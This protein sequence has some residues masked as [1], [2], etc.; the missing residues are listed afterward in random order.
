MKAVIRAP[1]RRQ[2]TKSFKTRFEAVDRTPCHDDREKSE[3]CDFRFS[4][5]RPRA[6]RGGPSLGPRLSAAMR[7]FVRVT[8][9][10]S[11]HSVWFS[12]AAGMSAELLTPRPVLERCT[13]KPDHHKVP[14]RYVNSPSAPI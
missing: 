7:H 6:V 1:G 10:A 5:P 14:C 2:S 12:L 13:F 3:K 11:R 9:H 4:P 8:H